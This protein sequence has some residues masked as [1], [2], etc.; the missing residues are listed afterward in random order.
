MSKFKRSSNW[1]A[2]Y[3][4][5]LDDEDFQQAFEEA[6]MLGHD[7]AT[8]YRKVLEIFV[9]ECFDMSDEVNYFLDREWLDIS[10]FNTGSK[11]FNLDELYT[12]WKEFL[13]Y[14]IENISLYEEKY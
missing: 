14:F 11:T 8:L 4:H 6:D 12:D 9:E 3:N 7:I 1:S 10:W 2:L 13:Q 5:L